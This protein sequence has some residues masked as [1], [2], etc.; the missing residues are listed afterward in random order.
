MKVRGATAAC[1]FLAMLTLASSARPQ[2]AGNQKPDAPAQEGMPAPEFVVEALDGK[3][4][5]LS[6]Y[7]G[8][9]VLLV[10]WSTG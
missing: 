9:L 3:R 8:R 2:D 5:S 6:D 7:R 1:A 4:I 10:F